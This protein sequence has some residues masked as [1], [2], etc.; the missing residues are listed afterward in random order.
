MTESASMKVM[1][2]MTSLT[3]LMAEMRNKD[4]VSHA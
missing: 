1:C 4:V 2:A 3:V